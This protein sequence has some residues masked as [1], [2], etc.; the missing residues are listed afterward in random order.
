MERSA[1]TMNSASSSRMSRSNVTMYPACRSVI[2]FL[3]VS[4][5]DVVG[6]ILCLACGLY[7]KLGIVLQGVDPALDVGVALRLGLDRKLAQPRQ[8]SSR[9][10]ASECLLVVDGVPI[11]GGTA[12]PI[13][14]TRGLCQSEEGG[15]ILCVAD[16][17]TASQHVL[18]GVIAHVIGVG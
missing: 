6:S 5:D 11:G 2:V 15:A 13:S 4:P 3:L 10:L 8:H 12:Q 9:H 1:L 14:V 7:R 17:I 16:G 18:G